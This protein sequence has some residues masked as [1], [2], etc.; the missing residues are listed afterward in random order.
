MSQKTE[1]IKQQV[2]D[3]DVTA[4]MESSFLEYAYSVIYSRALPD[5]RD[6]LK[7]VQR[8]ILYMMSEMGLS[9]DRGHVKSSR[10]IGEVM[11]KLHPHGDSAIYDALVRMAQHF[12]L[13]LPLIDG[14]GNFGSLDDG[15]AAPRYTEARLTS[16]ALHMT[17]NLSEDVV[18]FVPNYDNQF[19]QPEVLPA[20]Y[21]NLLVNGASG[22]AVGMATNMPPHNLFE[23][24]E[25]TKYL[26]ENPAATLEDILKF[27]PG[28][29][30]PT[31]GI[32]TNLDGILEAYRKGRGTFKTR[33]KVKVEK[34]NAR[35]N[36][37]V[38]TQ[39]PY[40]V[41]PERVIE[42][43]KEAVSS[44]KLQ[45][46]LAVTDLTDRKNGLRIVIEIKSEFNPEAVLLQLYKL[47]P[48]E[49]SFGINNVALVSGQPQ[50]LGLLELLQVYVQHRIQVVRRR[51]EFYLQKKV[52][53]L[54]LLEGLLIAILDIDK[55]IYIIRNSE[56]TSEA[57]VELMETFSLTKKQAEHI[58][59]LRLRS[60]TKLSTLDLE[61]QSKVLEEEI[62]D[63]R[64]I[65]ADEGKLHGVVS[66]ELEEISQKYSTPRRTVLLSAGLGS[67]E[68]LQKK[69]VAPLALKIAD[70][71]CWVLLTASGLLVR[72]DDQRPFP[73]I[74]KRFLHDVFRAVVATNVY[75]EVAAVTS[76]GRMV[77]IPVIDLPSLSVEGITDLSVALPVQEFVSL[78]VA[79]EVVTV[80]A[81]DDV[82][83]GIVLGTQLGVVKRVVPDY[84]TNLDSWNLIALKPG[85]KVVGAAVADDD[86]MCVFVTESAQ[87]LRYAAKQ[88]RPQKRNAAGMVGISL[89]TDDR[90][91]FF[92]ALAAGLDS[93][94]VVTLVNDAVDNGLTKVSS[95]VKITPLKDYPIKGRAT[96]GVRTH[97]FLKGQTMLHLAWVGESVFKA[98]DKDG[99]AVTLA[100]NYSARDTSGV[101]LN[102]KIGFIGKSL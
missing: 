71:P 88:V 57:A 85:D 81:F 56:Q 8:R 24:I 28:P 67:S 98:S 44:K 96:K 2:I 99:K 29:D 27:I 40:L 89:Q 94:V 48:L 84:P 23:V 78:E 32:I 12:S 73:R 9:P 37:L 75:G 22:I 91:I 21:P 82:Q 38:V 1:F 46:I 17:A 31:G 5:A 36:G 4:E 55:I 62:A 59:D 42:K 10:V 33:A 95:Y 18:D 6:G 87:L 74:V 93:S 50:V 45:G 19:M 25:A 97:R 26:L 15:P 51:S 72:T 43:I 52:A 69:V 53:Q 20:A 68:G 58:L 79:D 64:I 11:G 13:R 41:G 76:F 66:A 30:L 16:V 47:T 83:Q 70:E 61:T 102:K 77:K 49:D 90:V 39:L 63:L 92:T 101:I 65:L 54:H 60:L 14:H 34:I 86:D 100:V 35:R 3:I 80:V 7:P